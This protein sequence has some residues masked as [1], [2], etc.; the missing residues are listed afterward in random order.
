[1]DVGLLGG[2]FF[3][4]FVYQVDSAA[5]V[6]SLVPNARVRGGFDQTQWQQ[7]FDAI[8]RPLARV[9]AYLDKGGFMDKG[10]VRELETHRDQLRAS[11]EVLEGEANRASVPRGWRR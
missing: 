2:A 3:N 4:N 9:E 11:L 7:R 5:S 1:M 6:I 10:R 8:R